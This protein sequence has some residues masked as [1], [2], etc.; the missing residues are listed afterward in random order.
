MF[1]V[2]EM[3]SSLSNI[4]FKAPRYKDPWLWIFAMFFEHFYFIFVFTYV[5]FD[6]FYECFPLDWRYAERTIEPKLQLLY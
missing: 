5:F 1:K 6:Y 4:V 3:F 2:G